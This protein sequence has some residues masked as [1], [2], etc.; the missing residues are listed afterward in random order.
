MINTPTRALICGLDEAGRGA[1]AG[2]L[3]A[4][5]IILICPAEE[6]S[7][8]AGT[9]L[10][11]GKLLRHDQRE[12]LYTALKKAKANILIDIISTRSINNHGIGWANK[13]I[14]RRLIKKIEA[15]EY[16]VDG[17]LKIKVKGKTDRIRSII[18]ADATIA[19]VILAGIVA[20]VE[21]D[22]L[23]RTLHKQFPKYKW[24]DNAGYGTKK[25]REAIIKYQT[26]YYHR[27]IFVTTG[28]RNYSL[29]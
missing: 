3:V 19:E 15:A 29:S 16:I 26:T 12:K 25:H 9:M 8:N 23:M 10:K 2:P 28:L 14:F 11:D 24:H 22:K 13:E 6:I 1:W 21:R 18:D 4:A 7:R 20:K 27:S 17:N 5:A